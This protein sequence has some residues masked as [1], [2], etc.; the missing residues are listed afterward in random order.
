MG[1]IV[2]NQRHFSLTLKN[3]SNTCTVGYLKL[4]EIFKCQSKM[5]LIIH[6]QPHNDFGEVRTES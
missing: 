4:E 5:S 3:T 6:Y 2:D 1:L